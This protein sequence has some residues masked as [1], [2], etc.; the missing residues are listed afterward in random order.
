VGVESADGVALADGPAWAGGV[1]SAEVVLAGDVCYDRV[2]ARRVV[3]FATRAATRGAL[4]LL[5]D[6]G[7]AHFPATGFDAVGR[8]EVRVTGVLEAGDTTP[9]TVWR[10][11]PSPVRG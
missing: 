3:P 2:M 4:V 10:C 8:Y 11:R 9:T 1:E 5:G 6:P 7:R